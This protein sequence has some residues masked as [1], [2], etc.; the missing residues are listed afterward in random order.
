VVVASTANQALSG[1]TAFP[2]I[3]GI[4]TAANDRVLLKNQTTTNQNGIYIVGGTGTAWTLSR[5]TDM[6][7]WAEVPGSFVFVEKGTTYADTGWVCTADQGGTLGTTAIAWNQFAGTG[8]Y[9]G[10]GGIT[11]TGTNFALTNMAANSIKGNN[12][13]SSAAPTDLT[14]TQVTA[15]LD[16]FTSSLKGLAPASGGGTAN[17]LRADGTWA[18]PAG[19]GTTTN[20]VTFNNGGSGD[21]SGTTFNGTTAR[22]ISYNTV[23]AQASDATLTALAGLDTT[24][25]LVEQTATD[26]FTKRAI[27]VASS[28]SIPT[29]ADAD[30]RYVAVTANWTPVSATGTG[31]SQNI[32]LPEAVTINDVL[33]AIEGLIQDPEDYSITGTTLTM[34]APSGAS[35]KV[36]KLN[37][38][39]V[40]GTTKWTL[41]TTTSPS[42]VSTVD[43]NGLASYNEVLIVARNLTATVSGVRRIQVSTDNGTS[44]DNT[45]ANYL[46]VSSL[47]AESTAATPGIGFHGTNST[48]ARTLICH[49]K[50]L[51][52]AVKAATTNATLDTINGLYVGSSS[53]ITA[54]R[55]DNH[56]GGTISGGPI[57]IYAR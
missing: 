37:S 55:V 45:G 30:A 9:T 53:D 12:T 19:N 27:G 52:G 15:L 39:A 4:T 28:T 16:T 42:A 41:V 54:I 57:Y 46:S 18:A 51:K 34:T 11:L 21:A 48:A 49:I 38:G 24:V 20:T 26:T 35:I 7:S 47:G 29:R 23:G 10:S 8:T 25:G 56:T 40:S 6:D 43:V 50:N 3:D 32:T 14:G 36:R 13:G 17:Y 1:G 22:T 33:V 44:F 5:T 31:S 2:T